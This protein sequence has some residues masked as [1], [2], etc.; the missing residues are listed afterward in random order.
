MFTI[1]TAH[2]FTL[3]ALAMNQSNGEIVWTDFFNN[4]SIFMK[5][6]PQDC[7]PIEINWIIKYGPVT[8]L[9]VDGSMMYY[10]IETHE[11]GLQLVTYNGKITHIQNVKNVIGLQIYDDLL[12]KTNQNLSCGSCD[13]L[14]LDIDKCVCAIGYWMSS[15]GLCEPI[16]DVLLFSSGH[17]IRGVQFENDVSKG[18][19][20]F[21][22]IT[23]LGY[24]TS[25]DYHA[26]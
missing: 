22:G 15:V 2:Y 24:S 19:E 21:V 12:M 13:H 5:C 17:Q 10:T 26:S 14:C 18:E 9:L 8:S 1:N 4:Q 11:D 3:E 25:F 16:N 20:S 7:K 23:N 6:F